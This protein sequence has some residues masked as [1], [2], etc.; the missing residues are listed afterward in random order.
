LR[1]R[2]KDAEQALINKLAKKKKLSKKRSDAQF[3][4]M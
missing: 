4:K 2:K 3:I 1:L